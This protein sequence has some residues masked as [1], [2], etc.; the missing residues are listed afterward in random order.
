M[1]SAKLIAPPGEHRRLR[2]RFTGPY[3]VKRKVHANAYQLEGL[4]ESMPQTINVTYLRRFWPTPARL[5]T[6]PGQQDRALPD[7]RDDHYEW[8]VEAIVD[9][10]SGPQG[11]RYLIQWKGHNQPSWLRPRQLKN[12]ASI[13]REY[14]RQHGLAL[15][16]WDDESSELESESDEEPRRSQRHLTGEGRTGS[17]ALTHS[18]TPPDTRPAE[19]ARTNPVPNTGHPLPD[20]RITRSMRRLLP[21][22]P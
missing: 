2:A 22:L 7:K 17:Q 4:P 9:H 20:R 19:L 11:E 18:S 5:A 15:N 6:R 16:F 8:E 13:L 21:A 10:R 1:V 12:C 3:V 14:Q